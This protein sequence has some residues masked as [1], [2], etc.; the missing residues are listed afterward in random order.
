MAKKNLGG[1]PTVM[2]EEVV[3]KL[4]EGF[5]AD[6]TI[7]EA[8]RYAGIDQS[9][10]FRRRQVDEAFCKEMDS[11]KDYVLIKAKKNIQ[12]AVDEGDTDL[13]VKLLKMRQN[14][15][16]SE[17][18]VSEIEGEV[19]IKKADQL[20]EAL[21]DILEIKEDADNTQTTQSDTGSM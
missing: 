16:Y 21:D 9:T 6:F 7:D 5:K 17:R 20:A 19:G 13:S 11:A 18:N 8:C 4:V 12:T 3:A 2:T 10:Y 1:R 14:K 15:I